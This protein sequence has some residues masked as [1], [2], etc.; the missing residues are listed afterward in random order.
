M[1]TVED[2]L[3]TIRLARPKRKNAVHR[4]MY[5]GLTAGLKEAAEDDKTVVTA[6]TGMEVSRPA[7]SAKSGAN[8]SGNRK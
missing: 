4:E 1:V 3:R 2:G 7:A 8:L 5:L 6:I